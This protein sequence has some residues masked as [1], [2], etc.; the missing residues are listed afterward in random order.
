M[1]YILCQ[2]SGFFSFIPNGTCWAGYIKSV[3]GFV[4]LGLSYF[5][6]SDLQLF[7]IFIFEAD[8]SDTFHD[9]CWK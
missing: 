1:Q 8:F 4:L 9:K 2:S 6:N 7:A 3:D 5:D